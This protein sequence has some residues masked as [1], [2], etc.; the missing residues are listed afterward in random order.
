MPEKRGRPLSGE[1]DSAAVNRRREQVRERMRQLRMRQRET[2]AQQAR[3]T[4]AQ[5]EQSDSFIALPSVEEE[6]AATTSMSLGIRKSPDLQVPGDPLDAQL[7]RLAEDV[8]EHLNLYR[9]GYREENE[10]TGRPLQAPMH[11]YSGKD[12]VFLLGLPP[13]SYPNTDHLEEV[14]ASF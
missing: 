11:N 1:S 14:T 9:D 3:V 4:S 6:E 13:N 5:H 7:Q 12:G 8:N 2:S 10:R